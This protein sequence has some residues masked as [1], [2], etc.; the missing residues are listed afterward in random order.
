MQAYRIDDWAVTEFGDAELGDARRT[1][2][3]THLATVLGAQP[4]ASLPDATDDPATLTAADRFFAN[5]AVDPAQILASHVQA[6]TARLR[7]VPLVLAVQ[8]TTYL[9]WTH[10][11]ATTGL[12]P[13][14]QATQQGLLAHTTLALT[15]ERVPLGLRAQEVWARDPATFAQQVDHK[16]RSITANE[17]Q[18]WLTSVAAVAQLRDACPT[19]QVVCVGVAD[20]DVYALFP[21]PRPAGVDLL[22]RAGQNRRVDDPA[23]YL[24]DAV[25]AAPIA[26]TRE[27]VVPGRAGHPAR[28]GGL[29]VQWR[30]VTVRPPGGGKGDGDQGVTVLWHGVQ[31]QSLC[32]G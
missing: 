16:Q 10:H 13:L 3:L 28:T 9:D 23:G 14:A 27:G 19:T 12:G 4:T 8:D 21:A 2:R 11:P 32:R 31:Q 6:T 22:V 7:Q 20:A 1:A 18:Q 24:W 29:T 26:A 25:A 5:E 30:A 17:S 15:P